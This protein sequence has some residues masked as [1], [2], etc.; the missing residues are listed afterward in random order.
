MHDCVM[1]FILVIFSKKVL[2]QKHT[3]QT[4]QSHSSKLLYQSKM[5][6]LLSCVS[7]IVFHGIFLAACSTVKNCTVILTNVKCQL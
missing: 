4:L 6:T 5:S 1:F 7:L 2:L 3:A